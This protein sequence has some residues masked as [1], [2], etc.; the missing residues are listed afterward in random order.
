MKVSS[1]T[2][3]LVWLLCM[4]EYL[5]D[6]PNMSSVYQMLTSNNAFP[7]P[8]QPGI[9]FARRTSNMPKSKQSIQKV[10]S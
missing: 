3:L 7:S 5:E 8:K 10:L 4:Q 6:R 9:F 1:G 2:L